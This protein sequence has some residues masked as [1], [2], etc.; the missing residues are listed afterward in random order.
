M[1]KLLAFVALLLCICSLATGCGKP[2]TPLEAFEAGW[3][4]VDTSPIHEA[5]ARRNGNT[6]CKKCKRTTEGIVFYC[7]YCGKKIK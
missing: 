1:K 4:K 7:G 3:E 2:Q 6:Y 5:D